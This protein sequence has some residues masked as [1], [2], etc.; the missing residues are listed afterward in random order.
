M[1]YNKS[2][3]LIDFGLPG[4]N[5]ADHTLSFIYRSNPDNLFETQSIY[6]SKINF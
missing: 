3:E 4:K 5:G 6:F 1:F 2:G